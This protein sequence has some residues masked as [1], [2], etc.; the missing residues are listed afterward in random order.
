VCDG[1]GF[2][3]VIV[4]LRGVGAWGRW[5]AVGGEVGVFGW[6]FRCFRIVDLR[7]RGLL[8]GGWVSG[9]GGVC[10]VGVCG[11]LLVWG[12]RF[13][14]VGELVFD[15]WAVFGLLR[16]WRRVLC[17]LDEFLSVVCMLVGWGG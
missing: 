5:C 4:W 10:F 15:G 7:V 1:L 12:V 3:W 17:G 8:V 13:V 14:G 9:C 6:R 2:D 16:L 11:W